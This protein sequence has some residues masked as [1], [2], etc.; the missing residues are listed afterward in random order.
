M[1]NCF[2]PKKLP[3]PAR[4]WSRWV[5]LLLAA[6]V[7]CQPQPT[8]RLLGRWKPDGDSVVGSLLERG[9]LSVE[10][11]ADGKFAVH[12]TLPVLGTVSKEATWRYVRSDGSRIE[13]ELVWTDRSAPTRLV[14]TQVD[15]RTIEFVPPI[16]PLDTP[17][18]FVREAG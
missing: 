7:G 11:R 1:V 14:V 4:F 12:L 9:A 6:V 8:T 10:F 15:E 5:A 18:R 17:V 2:T 16:K 3:G 13:L